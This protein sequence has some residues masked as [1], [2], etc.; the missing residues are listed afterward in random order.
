MRF[1]PSFIKINPCRGIVDDYKVRE[2]HLTLPSPQ[3]E[4]PVSVRLWVLI[5]HFVAKKDNLTFLAGCSSL[6][7]E[8]K[9]GGMR[10]F[11]SFIK[12]NPCRGVVDDYKVRDK[13]VLLLKI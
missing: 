9:G 12:I 4:G 10:C 7:L 8:E 1:F 2:Y 5:Q 6:L 3:G 13:I 11:L